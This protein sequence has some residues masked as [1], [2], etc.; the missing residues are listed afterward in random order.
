MTARRRRQILTIVGECTVENNDFEGF[1]HDFELRPQNVL[2]AAGCCKET[3]CFPPFSQK[4][5]LI[6][7]E[8]IVFGSLPNQVRSQ[9][10][11]R[12]LIPPP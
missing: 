8:L 12:T 5:E 6:D 10:R 7:Q 9:R 1:S 11:T 3:E 4:K 2:P